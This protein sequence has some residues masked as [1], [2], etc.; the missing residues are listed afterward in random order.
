MKAKKCSVNN[1]HISPAVAFE[2]NQLLSSAVKPFN[3]PVGSKWCNNCRLRV[4][5]DLKSKNLH[6][7]ETNFCMICS[8]VHQ[9]EVDFSS[10][11]PAKKPRTAPLSD[12][13]YDCSDKSESFEEETSKETFHKSMVEIASNY[14]SP[15][16]YQ[17]RTKLN[18][19]SERTKKR[20]IRKSL[21]A[22]DTV[23]DNIVPGQSQFIMATLQNKI[24]KMMLLMIL[25]KRSKLLM[26][27]TIKYSYFH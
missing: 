23:L 9:K 6:L 4:H 13:K 25:E 11:T 24:T 7:F 19:V 21:Q 26:D 14:W 12:D 5:P 8:N 1:R 15:I 16:K 3:I 20:I 17:L 27:L 18:D 22:V 2:I 10:N